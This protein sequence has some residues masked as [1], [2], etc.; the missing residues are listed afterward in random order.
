MTA[1]PISKT[2]ICK[3]CNSETV[4]W[5]KSARTGKFYLVEVFDYDGVLKSDRIDFHSRY[6]GNPEAHQQEQDEIHAGFKESNQWHE[7]IVRE[8]EEIS[9]VET[10]KFFLNLHD[11]CKNDRTGSMLRLEQLYRNNNANP[12][13]RTG[14][15][16]K[17]MEAALGLT[18]YED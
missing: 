7:E 6:C 15:E 9:A 13:A 14:T 5:A 17:F 3:R 4:S 16:I 10:A 2:A 18:V 8:R 12:D 11:L 1:K